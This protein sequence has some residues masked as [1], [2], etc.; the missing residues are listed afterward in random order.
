MKGQRVS[1]NNIKA[2]QEDKDVV[3]KSKSLDLYQIGDGTSM[4]LYSL[5]IKHT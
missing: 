4:R 1:C 2:A 5:V 3:T